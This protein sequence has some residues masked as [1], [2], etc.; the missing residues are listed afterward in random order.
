MTEPSAPL[1]ATQEPHPWGERLDALLGHLTELEGQI[2]QARRRAQMSNPAQEHA[3]QLAAEVR[4]AE[5]ARKAQERLDA[6]AAEV[7]AAE[8]ARKA[9]E[10]K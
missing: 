9:N 4:A 10:G 6:I 1:A 2:A 3:D 7:R 8:E 5:E